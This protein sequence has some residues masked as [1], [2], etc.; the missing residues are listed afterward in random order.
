M[1]GQNHAL[2]LATLQALL[3]EVRGLRS[4]LRHS[5]Q[6][7]SRRGLLAA[8][9][10]SVKDKEFNAA[11]LLQHADVDA[12][13]ATAFDVAQITTAR[14]LGLVLRR[15]EGHVV[16]HCYLE[17][18]DVDRDGIVWKVVRVAGS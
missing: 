7:P 10:A 2:V 14:Q 6:R 16:D 13:L 15:L 11:E 17:R 18:L 12:T 4:D 9:A 1:R 8:I 3:Q 5:R